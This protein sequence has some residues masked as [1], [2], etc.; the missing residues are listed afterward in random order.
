MKC[1][2]HGRRGQKVD[3]KKEAEKFLD[4][5]REKGFRVTEQRKAMV[6]H[7]LNFSTP[8]SAEELHIKLKNKGVDLTTV[9][10]SLSSFA[11]VE[12][13]RPV[14]F[15]DGTLRYEYY[16]FE[17]KHHHH[18][19]I[20]KVCQRVEA[21]ESCEV[22]A[23]ENLVRKMGYQNVSHRLEFFGTCKQCAN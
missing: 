14:D 16:A 23:Q 4:K 11:D 5:L 10:R 13:L 6:K 17:E 7:I 19:V 9:Y 21:I 22:E 15:A 2:D 12:L 1:G 20:C 18:H 8:F 3:L